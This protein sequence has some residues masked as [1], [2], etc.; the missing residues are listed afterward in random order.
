MQTLSEQSYRRWRMY[1]DEEAVQATHDV[2]R[3]DAMSETADD[4]ERAIVRRPVGD[5]WADDCMDFH[6]IVLEGVH[7]HWCPDWDYLP[8]DETCGEYHLSEEPPADN[9]VPCK[10]CGH[11]GEAPKSE[12]TP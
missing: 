1:F 9:D 11:R 2:L 12:T 6:G 4:R 7:G 8:I 5:D 3:G 10:S